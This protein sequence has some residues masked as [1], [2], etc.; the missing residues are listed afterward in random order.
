[1]LRLPRHR[2]RLLIMS[3]LRLVRLRIELSTG[4]YG[5]VRARTTRLG[6]VAARDGAAAE[7]RD[8]EHGSEQ[9]LGSP[10]EWAREVAWSVPRA[11]R[12]VPGASC[13]VQALAA[14]RLLR[15]R[16]VSPTLRIGVLPHGPGGFEAHAWLEHD[17]GVIVGDRDDL[18]RYRRLPEVPEDGVRFR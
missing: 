15:E 7:A 5:E 3:W 10:K 4:P 1:M 11:A 14:E 8:A 17:G 6:P 18:D 13:L 9:R 2:R 12:L 16:G